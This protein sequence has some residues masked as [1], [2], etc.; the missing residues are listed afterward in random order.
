[1][2]LAELVKPSLALEINDRLILSSLLSE[3]V[4]KETQGRRP[5]LNSAADAALSNFDSLRTA[6]GVS[7]SSGCPMPAL[8][9]I[10]AGIDIAGALNA[11]TQE[12]RARQDKFEAWADRYV[13]P[14]IGNQVTARELY[15]ARCGMVHAYSTTTTPAK[16]GLREISYV[17]YTPEKEMFIRTLNAVTISGHRPDLR[18]FVVLSVQEL[19]I[20]YDEGWTTM[21]M[22]VVND[23]CRRP[24][25]EQHCGEQFNTVSM[26]KTQG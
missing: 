21:L 10:Y 16:D 23:S 12:Y 20:A 18:P 1:M 13:L 22:E 5:R 14:R 8:M 6:I 9:L 25:F 17:G 19:A 3:S 4:I 2:K 15:L 26:P 24:L 11:Q 7:I